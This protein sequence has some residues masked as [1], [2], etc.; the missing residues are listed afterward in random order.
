MAKPEST[1]K[2]GDPT[3][4][5]A[6]CSQIFQGH[7][8]GDFTKLFESP[9]LGLINPRCC[10]VCLVIWSQHERFVKKSERSGETL[11]LLGVQYRVIYKGVIEL[12]EE[13]LC[14]DLE[15][16]YTNGHDTRVR[17]GT[18]SANSKNP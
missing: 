3:P 11:S 6:I 18:V 1:I 10:R 7:Y 17:F 5:C 13:I 4:L 2:P 9:D 15:L 16:T 12:S 14:W 8:E